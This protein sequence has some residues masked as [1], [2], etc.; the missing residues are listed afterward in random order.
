MAVARSL[1][2]T[3]LQIAMKVESSGT[4]GP[5]KLSSEAVEVRMTVGWI[6]VDVVDFTGLSY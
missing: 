4:S 6:S 1:Y 2:V 3:R 5:V